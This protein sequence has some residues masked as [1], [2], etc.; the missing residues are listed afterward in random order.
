MIQLS[1]TTPFNV[2]EIVEVLPSMDCVADHENCKA[3]FCDVPY[4]VL[5]FKLPL[6]ATL[7]TSYIETGR[8]VAVC[9]VIVVFKP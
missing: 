3:P 5:V 9:S 7:S 4:H 2:Q 6:N 8:A 1:F